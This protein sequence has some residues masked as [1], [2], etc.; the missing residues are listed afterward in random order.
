MGPS[1]LPDVR[2]P[3]PVDGGGPEHVHLAPVLKVG[4]LHEPCDVLDAEGAAEDLAVDSDTAVAVLVGR[5]DHHGRRTVAGSSWRRGQ[6]PVPRHRELRGQ[7]G[8]LGMVEPRGGVAGQAPDWAG[9]G[10]PDVRVT[11]CD[12]ETG[13]T[14]TEWPE[15]A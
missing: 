5:V 12:E 9:G 7:A 15:E 6:R 1:V 8:H 2:A 13:V 10:L 3:A 14:L 11:L 4:L